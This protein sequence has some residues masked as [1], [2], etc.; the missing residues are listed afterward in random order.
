M[1]VLAGQLGDLLL[2]F[3]QPA[4]ISELVLPVEGELHSYNPVKGKEA[5]M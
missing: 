3:T 1:A 2:P 4:T 5:L